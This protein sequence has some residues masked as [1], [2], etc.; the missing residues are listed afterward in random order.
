MN[1]FMKNQCREMQNTL[2]VFKQ[3]L[4]VCA[5]QDDGV[6]TKSEQKELDKINKAVDELS[7]TLTRAMKG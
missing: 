2:E 4:K 5:I 6:I 7:K 3:S 1:E